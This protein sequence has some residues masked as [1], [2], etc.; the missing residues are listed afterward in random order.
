M[1]LISSAFERERD[2]YTCMAGT[3]PFGTVRFRTESASQIS[4][5]IS[6][7]LLC[8]D[9]EM[10]KFCKR[11]WAQR[12]TGPKKKK[13]RWWDNKKWIKAD[14]RIGWNLLTG[15]NFV[16]IACMLADLFH[17]ESSI[18][19]GSLIW[20]WD[21]SS[22]TVLVSRSWIAIFV[23]FLVFAFLFQ[24]CL[25]RSVRPWCDEAYDRTAHRGGR[26]DASQNCFSSGD[27]GD[28]N[29]HNVL[30][31][32]FKGF[33]DHD[34]ERWCVC[35]IGRGQFLLPYS[36]PFKPLRPV[37]SWCISEE[38]ECRSHADRFLCR[39]V[40]VKSSSTRHQEDE[41]DGDGLVTGKKKKKSLLQP[42]QH[43]EQSGSVYIREDL[44]NFCC[45][46]CI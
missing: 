40:A 44:P 34:V 31:D 16:V 23:S 39:M 26:C 21:P 29:T 46:V 43:P 27:D 45:L 11:T 37:F 32:F 17:P 13:N 7:W 2:F 6:A 33:Q 1:I 14:M 9:L 12:C 30:G 4:R 42:R 10:Y 19:Q 25:E 3:R 20:Y 24:L 18:E 8:R 5:V 22:P 36:L 41:G 15:I 38:E 35:S 28:H